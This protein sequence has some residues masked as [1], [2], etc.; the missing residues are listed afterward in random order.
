MKTLMSKKVSKI[1]SIVFVSA[2][3]ILLFI[4]ALTYNQ[5]KSMNDAEQL[6]V[7]T[8][9]VKLTLAQLSNNLRSAETN[10]RGYII[11]RDS[12]YLNTYHI[13]KL[14]TDSLVTALLSLTKDNK[15]QTE[16]L[17]KIRL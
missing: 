3:F 5:I 9:K 7:H 10:Q 13:Y 8:Y 6:I 17:N 11:T 2:I 4:T 16:K 15:E 1:Y 14:K 12:S